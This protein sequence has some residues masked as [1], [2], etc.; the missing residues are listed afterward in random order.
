MRSLVLSL[1]ALPL[2]SAASVAAQ[3][4]VCGDRHDVLDQLKN[5]FGESPVGVG[6]T[7]QGDVLELTTSETGTWTLMLSFADGKSCL[8]SS[9]DNWE[10]ARPRK[11]GRD[12]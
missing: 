11:A 7:D 10:T 2:L 4:S 9:G 5:K 3:P 8:I 12:A 6:L 1:I